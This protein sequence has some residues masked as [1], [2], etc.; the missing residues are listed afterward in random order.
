MT[1][2]TQQT[3]ADFLEALAAPTPAPGGGAA[4]AVSGATA[5]ALV[6]MVAGLSLK[7]V[8]ES[9]DVALD[10]RKPELSSTRMLPQ[11]PPPV[12]H[13]TPES[14]S[15]VVISQADIPILA[16]EVRAACPNPPPCMVTLVEPVPA[17]FFLRI[18]L[19]SPI[20]MLIPC[21]RVP[22]RR[23]DDNDSLTLPKLKCAI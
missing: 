9:A 18:T 13:R 10:G 14:D 1:S 21:V 2:F 3:L 7:K 12:R 11:T 4:A 5:A 23:P 19:I 8:P 17:L 15:Q 16:D 20:S 22:T 6:E